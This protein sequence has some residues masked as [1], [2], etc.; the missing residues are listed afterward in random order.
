MDAEYRFIM[1]DIGSY[2]RNSDGGIFARSVI[3]R[4]FAAGQMNV[5][6]P[7]LLPGSDVVAPYTMVGD[8]A[9]PLSHYMMRPYPQLQS[10]ADPSKK[11]FNKRLSRAR[12]IV[13]NAFGILAQRWRIYFRPL[14]LGPNSVNIV[15]LTTLLLHNYLTPANFELNF[16]ENLPFRSQS[17]QRGS[18]SAAQQQRENMTFREN[19]RLYLDNN[20]I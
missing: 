13:E 12:R 11:N 8:Q 5:P 18:Q 15:V 4:G 16:N 7:D 14:P 19:L 3:G 9:F 10:Q 2:G 17:P 6:E 20:R 1:A